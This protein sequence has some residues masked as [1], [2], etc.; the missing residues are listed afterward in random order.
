MKQVRLCAVWPTG[1][2]AWLFQ[3]WMTVWECCW[4]VLEKGRLCT[5]MEKSRFR[6]SWIRA[7]PRLV[8]KQAVN[9]LPSAANKKVNLL[10]EGGPQRKRRSARF[11]PPQCCCAFDCNWFISSAAATATN[12][13]LHCCVKFHVW[14]QF[15]QQ[16][17]ERES[18]RNKIMMRDYFYK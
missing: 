6:V 5:A 17:N 8:T 12:L 16:T 7:T 3:G 2:L 18:G 10:G 15:L 13:L 4:H 11:C 14:R 1:E 9:L